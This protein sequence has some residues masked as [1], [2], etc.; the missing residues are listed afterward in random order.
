MA[1]A[2]TFPGVSRTPWYSREF[3]PALL[4]FVA[5]VVTILVAL[6][7]ASASRWFGLMVVAGLVSAAVSAIKIAQARHKDDKQSALESPSDLAGFLLTLYHVVKKQRQI[8]DTEADLKRLR[9]TI[10]NVDGEY[11]KQCVDYV[12]G[13]GGTKTLHKL[14]LRT[15]VVGRAAM[16]GKAVVA[17]RMS[18]DHADFIHELIE[19]YH[20]TREEA[21]QVDHERRAWMA[22]PILGANQNPLAVVYLDSVDPGF[23][24][25]QTQDIIAG[26]C[27]GLAQYM[28]LRHNRN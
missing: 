15:G 2:I 6:L 20:F 3:A 14:S 17:Q 13:N 7:N 23:F 19:R 21:E 11:L 8:G 1:S 4:T 26:G 12:G 28:R 25:K 10:Y 27:A 24:N 5:S 18:H 9:L 22:V 16:T